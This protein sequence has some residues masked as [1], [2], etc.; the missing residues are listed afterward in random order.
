MDKTKELAVEFAEKAYVEYFINKSSDMIMENC[1]AYDIPI[2][3]LSTADWAEVYKVVSMYSHID[4]LSE[5]LYFTSTRIKLE[6][7]RDDVDY[8]E[9]RLIDATMVCRKIGEEHFKICSLHISR[10]DNYDFEQ[11]SSKAS[12]GES[13][14][15]KV[16]EQT[17]DV[18]IEYD[19]VNNVFQYDPE[20]YK[21]HFGVATHF[22]SADQWF[23]HMC[24]ECVMP[25]DT[26]HLDIFRSS[27]IVKRIR[28]KDYVVERE[29]RIKNKE[30]N[31]YIWIRMTIVF[32]PNERETN[33]SNIFVMF[34]NIDEEKKKDL[35]YITKA[36]TDSLTGLSNREYT[37]MLIEEFLGDNEKNNGIF[38]VLDIDE[39]K[40][41][42]DT[43]GHLTGDELL[44]RT[45]KGLYE[46]VGNNDIVGRI[47]GDEFVIFLKNIIDEKVAKS[48]VANILDNVRY[49]YAEGAGSLSVRCSAGAALTNGARDIDKIYKV[50]DNNLYESKRAGRNTFRIT[51]M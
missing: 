42:N 29:V 13:V 14:Y 3:G 47:G 23:W 12:S 7:T 31:G 19:V 25:Q 33:L 43:F 11:I 4:A 45:A 16:L 20:K 37:K 26:E 5:D 6:D 49:D 48:K 9:K 44:K 40:K 28:N 41:V 17:Y 46:S 34:K 21:E 51:S 27:D 32:M 10:T 39:F 8:I 35:D 36:R 38:I 15:R 50:A 1:M 18:I 2:F 24:T 30:K 22:V